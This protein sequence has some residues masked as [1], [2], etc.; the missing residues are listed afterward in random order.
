MGLKAETGLPDGVQIQAH[1]GVETCY[2]CAY[3]SSS[4][5]RDVE[6]GIQKGLQYSYVRYAP[7]TPRAEDQTQ[8]KIRPAARKTGLTTFVLVRSR[9]RKG[10]DRWYYIPKK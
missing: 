1:G 9:H 5:F 10:T 4:Y 7:D 2:D 3:A 8:R 6:T